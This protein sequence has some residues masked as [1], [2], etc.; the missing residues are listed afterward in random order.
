MPFWHGDRPGRPLELGRALQRMHQAHM[1]GQDSR[2]SGAD[3]SLVKPAFFLAVFL[4]NLTYAFL[5]QFM[6]DVVAS[7]G[8]SSAYTSAPFMASSRV[9]ASVAW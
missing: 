1:S 9:R 2:Q 4:E 6:R 5:P 8:I 3:I 7:Y